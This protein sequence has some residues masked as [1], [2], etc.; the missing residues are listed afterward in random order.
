M[1][2][3]RAKADERGS[4]L[5]LAAMFLPIAVLAIGLVV[6]LGLVFAAKKAAQAAC[7]LGA[8]AGVQEIDLDLLA[9]GEVV[10]KDQEARFNALTTVHSNLEPYCGWF[11][12]ADIDVIVY[13]LPVREEPTVRV[14]A[15]ISVKVHF[16]KWL[17]LNPGV[18][19]TV[20]SEAS[21]VQRDIF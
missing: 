18:T 11:N 20:V 17:A 9:G 5:A 14:E 15:R 16:L 19:C 10:I 12:N 1:N 7:D 2:L 13:N 3:S 21:V 8:L 6:D 4:V